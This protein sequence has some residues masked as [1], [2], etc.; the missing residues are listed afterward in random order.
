MI[1]EKKERDY[2]WEDIIG[3]W[4]EIEEIKNFF[5]SRY[6]MSLMKWLSQEYNKGLVTPSPQDVF[7][8]FRLVSPDELKVIIITPEP[9]NNGTSNGLGLGQK[10]DVKRI[11]DTMLSIRDGVELDTKTID[12]TFD[13]TLESWAKQ[14]V[15]LLN[16]TPTVKLD[17]KDSH[18]KQWEQFLLNLLPIIAMEKCGTI[19]MLWGEEVRHLEEIDGF[20]LESCCYIKKAVHPAFAK[21]WRQPWRCTNFSEA[22][23][24]L[25]EREIKSKEKQTIRWTH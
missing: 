24:I 14:G 11:S 5:N 13:I 3:E 1:K 12:I 16:Q 8:P 10:D 17:E 4:Y 15:L 2:L 25:K 18:K 9:L 7:R 6:M 19:I 21:K 20:Q 22:N 23:S